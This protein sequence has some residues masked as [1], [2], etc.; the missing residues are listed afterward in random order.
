[1]A[2]S[3]EEIIVAHVPLP[4]AKHFRST[5]IVSSQRALRERDLFARYVDLLPPQHHE[6]VLQC[7]AATWVPMAD[8]VAHYRACDALELS[9]DEQVAL[10]EMVSDRVQGSIFATV[11]KM[12]KGAGVTPWTIL[13]HFRRLWE[14]GADGGSVAV[15]KRGPKEAR[16]E[17][18]G[19]A[20]FEIPYFRAAM[21]GVITGIVKQFC[22]KAFISEVARAAAPR[23][24]ILLRLQWV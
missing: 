13:P 6:V 9:T 8:V 10:G 17:L 22:R 19:C 16:I 5:W 18:V 14:R 7:V 24:S 15:Y 20:L 12:A 23:D 1:M 4:P 21:R 3:G 11:V 2:A